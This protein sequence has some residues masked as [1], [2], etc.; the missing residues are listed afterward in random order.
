MKPKLATELVNT[1]S[2]GHVKYG[3]WTGQYRSSREPIVIGS[4][5]RSGTTL[6]RAMLNA[7]PRFH[8]GPETGL[9]TGS[10]DHLHI[11]DAL[12][13]TLEQVRECEREASTLGE[14]VERLMAKSL[15]QQ[16]HPE[17]LRWGEKTPANIK[18]VDRIFHFFPK[19][20]FIHMIRDGRDVACSLRHHPKF[21]WS[22]G[23]RI[24]VE[25]TNEWADCVQRWVAA[26]RQG[27]NWR[28]DDRYRELHYEDL[29]SAPEETLK[30]L[31]AWLNEDWD[32]CVL[33]Y[34]KTH[35]SRSSD[36]HNPGVKSKLYTK[37]SNR[38]LDDLPAE[39][40]SAFTDEAHHLLEV[41]GY[42]S[43]REWLSL[44]K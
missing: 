31:L 35:E 19:A 41:L 15:E 44:L 13:L 26:T 16:G 28:H 29:V 32:D 23:T 20:R 21:R 22:G 37:A 24:P 38:W 36:I 1:I 33:Q 27:L 43:D 7:H 10:Q 42:A 39:A 2:L 8:I 3:W 11:A 6:L 40:G 12:N 18:A 4:C 17:D 25:I 9:F 14:Y 34:Y 5:G 30:D